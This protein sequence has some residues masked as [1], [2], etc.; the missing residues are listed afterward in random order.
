[1]NV[2]GLRVFPLSQTR[3]A[4][5]WFVELPYNCVYTCDKLRDVFLVRYY[6][7]YKKINHRDKVKNF[8]A[9]H[10]DFVSSSSV[11]FT[12]FMRGV[13]NNCIDDAFLKFYF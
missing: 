2:I 6:P 9:L 7:V 4:A 11:R 5:I 8:M 1:M 3:D 10:G 12:L 13:P